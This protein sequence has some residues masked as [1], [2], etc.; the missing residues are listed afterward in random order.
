[1]WEAIVTKAGLDNQTVPYSLR[2]TSIV[3]GL[4]V[5]LPARLVAA[6]HDTSVGMIEKHYAAYVVDAMNDLAARAVLELS[7]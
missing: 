5:G 6:L 2:H 7:A 4:R 1:V 3:R